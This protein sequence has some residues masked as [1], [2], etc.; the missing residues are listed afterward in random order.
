[1]STATTDKSKTKEV[2]ER[3]VLYANIEPTKNKELGDG[4][5]EA[6]ITSGKLDHHGESVN[7]DGVDVS[8]YHG[9]V[10]YGH[11]Y[12]GLPIGKTISL[13]KMKSKIKARFQ[14]FTDV[15]P[16]ADLV[17][18]LILKGGLTDVSIGGLVKKWSDDYTVIEEMVMKEFSVVPIGAN[19]DAVITAKSLGKSVKDIKREY[20]DFVFKSQVDKMKKMPD[21]EINQAVR[22]L[23][24][25][26]ATLK[27]AAEAKSGKGK[28]P[29]EEEVKQILRYTLLDSA[30][31]VATQSQRVIKVIKLKEQKSDE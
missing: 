5:I 12:E 31:A 14:L 23:E 21:D 30:K 2:G 27:D 15:F 4:V 11:D 6:V 1:M 20:R 19:P 18:Q 26:T 13:T 24:R 10:L 17:Y 16:F 9:P 7:V 8:D 29:K 3:R 25:L 22:V 28:T